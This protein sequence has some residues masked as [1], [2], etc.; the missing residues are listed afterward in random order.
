MTFASEG[1]QRTPAKQAE[2]QAES[3]SLFTASRSMLL[4][5]PARGTRSVIWPS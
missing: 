4:R 3:G 2:C 1:R 5:L